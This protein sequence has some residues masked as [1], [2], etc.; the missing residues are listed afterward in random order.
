MSITTSGAAPVA[1][2]SW[3]EWEAAL[4]SA[5]SAEMSVSRAASWAGERA[6]GAAWREGVAREGVAECEQ[7]ARVA[8]RARAMSGRI[9][10]GVR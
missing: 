10:E 9:S 6:A 1:M 5:E 8:A 7:A 3:R 4:E 2:A